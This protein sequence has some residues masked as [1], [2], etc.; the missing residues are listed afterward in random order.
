MQV[1]A[2]Q[3]LNFIHLRCSRRSL[4]VYLRRR[5]GQFRGKIYREVGNFVVLGAGHLRACGTVEGLIDDGSAIDGYTQ[6]TPPTFS[7]MKLNFEQTKCCLRARLFFRRR[8]YYI[9][10]YSRLLFIF[11]YLNQLLL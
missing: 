8:K 11:Y 6:C 10:S 3:L 5:H 2:M 4:G 9:F 1:F 7:A